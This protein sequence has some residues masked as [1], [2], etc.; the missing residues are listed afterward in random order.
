MQEI[1]GGKRAQ[2]FNKV[3]SVVC[4]LPRKRAVKNF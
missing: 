3:C 2:W 4:D 1:M